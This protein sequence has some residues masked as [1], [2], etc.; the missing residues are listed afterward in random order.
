MRFEKKFR[1]PLS[2]FNMIKNILKTISFHEAYPCRFISSVY[3]DSLDFKF[4]RD[5]INGISNRKKIRARFYD[6]NHKEI[7]IEEKIK[8][9]E[10]GYKITRPIRNNKHLILKDLE[11]NQ[12]FIKEKI[13]VP[14]EIFKSFFP[15]TY[16]KYLRSYFISNDGKTRI[17]LDE[18]ISYSKIVSSLN[19]LYIN[20][21]IPDPRG[22]VEIKFDQE[23]ELANISI[24]KITKYINSPP[25]RNSKYC[26]SIECLF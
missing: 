10:M 14:S 18:K 11:I 3:Y 16:I 5:S 15:V 6:N 12:T 7:K 24:D 25:T 1:I 13:R 17:T 20:T 9:A 19:V 26:N 2:E 21:D 8:I 23:N 4:Y 22:V